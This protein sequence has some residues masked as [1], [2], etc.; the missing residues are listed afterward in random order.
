MA[1][2]KRDTKL[3][4]EALIAKK[5]EKEAER[6]RSEE[7][8]IDSLGGAITVT[9]PSRNI[10]YK[11][12]DMAGDTLS[13]Q[14]YANKFLIYNA[15]PVFR[16]KELLEAYEVSDNV[17]IVDILLTMAEINELTEKLMVLGGITKPEKVQEE[18]KN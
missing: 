4:L 15:V 18:V 3:T 11:A 9:T 6:S 8:Y 5:A 2:K 14:V 10:F 1:N 17:E 12:M 7:V 16:S 13:S